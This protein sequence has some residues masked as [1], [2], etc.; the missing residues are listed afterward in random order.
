MNNYEYIIA[1]LP[2]I[3]LESKF[4]EGATPDDI[5]AEIK[6]GCS[7]KDNAIIDQLL[8]GFKDECLNHDFYYRALSSSNKFI[9]EYFR[10]DLNVRNAKVKYLNQA[11]GRPADMDVMVSTAEQPIDGGIFEEE[12][13]VNAALNSGDI[14][15]REKGIDDLMWNKIGSLV[16]FDYFNINVI[17]A[18]IAKIHIINRWY[19]LDAETG[20]EMF[21]KLVNEV[22]GTFKG[23]H[24]TSE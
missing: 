2:S 20:R 5:I 22:R 14:L 24:Y 11:L 15:S 23:V 7:K 6:N 12:A 1:G 8:D 3:T 17:L 13:A 16:L 4:H 10:F 19:K 18:F 9:K 21:K